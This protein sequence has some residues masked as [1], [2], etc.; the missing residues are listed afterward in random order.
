MADHSNQYVP[1]S[2]GCSSAQLESCRESRRVFGFSTERQPRSSVCSVCHCA[3]AREC[4]GLRA[5]AC[6]CPG[7][8]GSVIKRKKVSVV[9]VPG[10]FSR[11]SRSKSRQL[12]RLT[13]LTH[14]LS[15][16]DSS[17]DSLHVL[18]LVWQLKR[19]RPMSQSLEGLETTLCRHVIVT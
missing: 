18:L 8:C 12:T 11:A 4:S 10:A 15:L 5:C 17:L 16:Y 19:L 2:D 14:S 7:N 13:R 3:R 9:Q 1:H 6:C